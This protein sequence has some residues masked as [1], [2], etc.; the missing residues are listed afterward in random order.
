M[1]RGR[2]ARTIGLLLALL[3]HALGLWMIIR[4]D[5]LVVKPATRAG[6]GAI[7]Y[8][9]PLASATPPR[10]P[11]PSRPKP[12]VVPREKIPVRRPPPKAVLPTPPE[13]RVA[14]TQPVTPPEATPPTPVAQ[15]V[16][17]EDFSARIEA[18]R[19]RRAEARAQDPTL[20]EAPPA[21][22]DAQRANRIAR[23]NIAFSQRGQQA[24]RDDTGGVFQLRH[25]GVHTAE[26]SFRGW[27]TN[28]RR[29]WQQD[30]TVDQGTEVDIETAV[31]KRM[32]ELIR[33]H[34]TDEFIWD[35][36]GTGRQ[37][38]LNANPAYDAELRAF[39]LKEFFPT[40]TR[41]AGR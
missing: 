13:P 12:K 9:A 27:N 38:T 32:I 23:E 14:I 29:N 20:A 34:K 24:D 30:I 3:L 7:S 2:D 26:F 5:P 16:P 19:K 40:Y 6:E 37:V 11:P 8:I 36:R 35:S 18:A 15:A 17:E 21:E 39:L 4:R 10:P 1:L 22:T 31:V 28:F 33:T 25:V 41:R